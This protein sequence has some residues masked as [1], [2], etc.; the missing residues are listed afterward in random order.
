MNRK[1]SVESL[2]KRIPITCFWIAGGAAVGGLLLLLAVLLGPRLYLR[3]T[4]PTPTWEF[5]IIVR[6][7]STPVTTP[8]LPTTPEAT[9]ESTAT[10]EFLEA[11][12]FSVGDLVEIRG[13]EGDGLRIRESPG[14]E[15]EILFLG[16]ENEV[17]M[18]EGGPVNVDDLAWWYLVNPYN[19]D[20]RG[21]AVSIFLRLL[22]SE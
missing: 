16:L 6:S 17:F 7:T 4:L 9:P 19:T 2:I 12:V 13:T 20:K 22:E 14:F 5:S 11:S 10:P 21:W 18:V 1:P 8:Q 15:G 3:K